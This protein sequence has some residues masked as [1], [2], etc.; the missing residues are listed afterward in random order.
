MIL[1]TLHKYIDEADSCILNTYHTHHT[2]H[3]H[4]IHHTSHF[5]LT[6]LTAG[7][8]D[9]S[10]PVDQTLILDASQSS[11]T[12]IDPSAPGGSNLIY[13]WTCTIGTA[14]VNFGEDCNLEEIDVGG[15]LPVLSVFPFSLEN[16]QEYRFTVTVS[17]QDGRTDTTGVVV[18]PS[19]AN[20]VSV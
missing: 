3:T 18:T 17:S 12:N 14:S 15:S 10:F 13:A 8:T 19:A 11:D 16:G 4:H 6:F 1:Q 9:R 5:F 20:A 2:S 7:G